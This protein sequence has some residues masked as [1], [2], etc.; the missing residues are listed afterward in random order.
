M[1]Q[2]L[3]DD[4]DLV[5]LQ[6]LKQK[7]LHDIVEQRALGES[8]DVTVMLHEY[9]MVRDPYKAYYGQVDASDIVSWRKFGDHLYH[10]N[11]RGFKGSTEVNDAIVATLRDA[12][13]KFLYFNNGITFLCAE[14]EK[15]PLGGKTRTSG[16]FDCRGASVVNGAQTAGSIIS[17]WS[18]QPNTGTAKVMVRL[19]SLKDC[20]PD[21]G[22]DVTRATNTQNR[23][24]KRAFAALDE[25]QSR[26][27]SDLLLSLGKEYVFRTGD[28]PPAQD[29]GCTIDEVTPALACAH[30]DIS[31]CMTAKR[32]VSKL[33]EDV[34]QPPYTVLFNPS[35][36]AVKLWR[37]VEILRAV[38]AFLKDIQ[39]R[40]EGR[41]R[42]IAIHGNRLVLYLVFRALGP[43]TLEAENAEADMATVPQLAADALFTVT[44]E[45]MKNFSGAYPASLFKNVT[46]CKAIP[47]VAGQ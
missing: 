23:I 38:D 10:E 26:L 14:L 36:T 27:R 8:V 6:V 42:L 21:C 12:P 29:K 16:V 41:E 17:A 11:I 28:R 7:E 33:Y 15:Q 13:D 1:L 19:I 18:A 9:G 45:I 25:E 46:K 4:G 24:E 31:Y 47:S 35:L 20:P 22:F 5:S 30:P 40:T 39:A 34:K 37:A 43:N 32:E 44:A 3:N 2:D